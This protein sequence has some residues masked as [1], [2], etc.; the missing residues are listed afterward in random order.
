MSVTFNTTALKTRESESDPWASTIVAVNTDVALAP[1]VKIYDATSGSYSAGDYCLHEGHVYK[2]TASTSGAWNSTKWTLTTVGEEVTNVRN[3][4]PPVINNLTSDS[5]TSALSAAQG[6]ALKNSISDLFVGDITAQC[7]VNTNI[8]SAINVYQ[9]G[10][11][12]VITGQLKTNINGT[13]QL[14]VTLPFSVKRA[15]A[16]VSCYGGTC[17]GEIYIPDANSEVKCNISAS[18]NNGNYCI[19]TYKYN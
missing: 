18:S 15:Y 8:S 5:T 6:K 4:I 11:I 7:T 12:I 17:I 1:I 13:S 14:I 19:V 2:A 16:A 9:F 3:A 10:K